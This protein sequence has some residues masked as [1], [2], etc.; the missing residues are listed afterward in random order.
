MKEKDINEI[1]IPNGL[2]DEMSDLIDSM[3]AA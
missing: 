1:E 2:E 3:D